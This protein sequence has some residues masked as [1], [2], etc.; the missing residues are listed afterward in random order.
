[1]TKFCSFINAQIQLC[2]NIRQE[3]GIVPLPHDSFTSPPGLIAK[4]LCPLA[5]SNQSLFEVTGFINS[6]ELFL[7]PS[8]N[9]REIEA[10]CQGIRIRIF[11]VCRGNLRQPTEFTCFFT[12][13]F[14]VRNASI[15]T[16]NRDCSFHAPC[17]L[18]LLE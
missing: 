16:N 7:S 11:T 3:R 4:S 14:S 15:R 5:V 1:M 6:S 10:R 8:R 13:Q 12:R 9:L 2:L 18:S 17:I